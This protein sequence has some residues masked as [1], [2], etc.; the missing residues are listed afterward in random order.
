VFFSL[1]CCKAFAKQQA[2]KR[3]GLVRLCYHQRQICRI[4]H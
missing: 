3:Q 4:L 2:S 1:L